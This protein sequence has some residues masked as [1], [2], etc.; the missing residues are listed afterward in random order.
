MK[1]TNRENLILY[2]LHLYKVCDRRGWD[3]YDGMPLSSQIVVKFIRMLDKFPDELLGSSGD[4][5]GPCSDG[6]IDLEFQCP[7]DKGAF[8]T[9][10]PDSPTIQFEWFTSLQE[11]HIEELSFDEPIPQHV[12]D[13]IKEM[14]EK[15]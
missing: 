1:H 2:V 8:M 14:K 12:I 11:D 6:S 3:S 15:V 4:F 10:S 9:V 7:S 5:V 13:K